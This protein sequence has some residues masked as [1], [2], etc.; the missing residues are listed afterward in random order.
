MEQRHT[1][2]L[3]FAKLRGIADVDVDQEKPLRKA[4]VNSKILKY[5]DDSEENKNEYCLE[6]KRLAKNLRIFSKFSFNKNKKAVV[7]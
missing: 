7:K 4:R 3:K 5:L 2:Q 6:R 1:T